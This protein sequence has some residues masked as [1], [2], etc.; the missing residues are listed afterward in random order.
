MAENI[1]SKVKTATKWSTITEIAAKLVAPISTM[2]LAR[3]LT[4]ESFGV[5]VTATMVIS[6]AEIF[7]DAGFQKYIIQH[8]FVDDK[9]L[10]KSTNVAFWSNFIFSLLVW[11]GISLF[12]E[13]IARLVGNDGYGSVITISCVC[14][15]L[16]AF[17]SIQMALFKRKL[18]FKTLFQV[19]II[20]ILI[21][22]IITIP[23]AFLLRNYWSLI[24]GMIALNV[25]NAILL[26]WKSEWRPKFE[27]S[28]SCFKEMF[29]FSVWSMIEAISIWLTGYLD[30]FIVGTLLSSYHMGIYRTGIN[31][32]NHILVIITS[33]TTP[34]LFSA[35][36]RLQDNN[37]EFKKLFFRFQKIVGM[38]VI[39]MGVAIYLFNGLV[40]DVLLG[41][42]WEETTFLIGWWGLTSALTIV[43]SHYC[44]EV[45]RAKGE[46]KYSVLAQFIHLIF[47]IPTILI[48]VKYGFETLC[49][50]RSLVRLT[51]IAINLVLLYKLTRITPSDMFKNILHSCVASISMIIMYISLPQ[52]D[53]FWGQITYIVL[54][55]VTYLVCLCLFNEERR[56]LFSLKSIIKK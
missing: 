44:S 53:H 35:L 4:P 45:Y 54:C 24:I 33:A 16:A 46:P 51:L 48:S 30:V 29:S 38:L 14:I 10:Y 26:T 22:L 13:Q 21:P 19:R 27:Y 1:N 39:P 18:D 56:L 41:E 17:S 49:L 8:A 6:F 50:S 23:L 20:G 11:A 37:E 31:T 55:G 43:L 28:I 7:T 32:V 2:V 3:L 40:T 52:T 9:S 42:Q 15:P 36:S 5:L 34:I 12:S 47:L 25:S